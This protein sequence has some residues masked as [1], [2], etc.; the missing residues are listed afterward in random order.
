MTNIREQKCIK[1]EED[2]F[3]H[4]LRERLIGSSKGHQVIS[5][6]VNALFNLKTMICI[7]FLD[8]ILT[9]LDRDPD[10]YSKYLSGSG[11]A[12]TDPRM[13]TEAFVSIFFLQF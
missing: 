12:N 5:K 1:K 7:P 11:R 9:V 8:A 10:Q 4:K 3:S 13:N 6:M 2:L